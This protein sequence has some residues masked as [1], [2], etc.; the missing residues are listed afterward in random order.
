MR[1]GYLTCQI[2]NGASKINAWHQTGKIKYFLSH[3]LCAL[4]S[5]LLISFWDI[6]EIVELWRMTEYKFGCKVSSYILRVL[7][8]IC[9][10]CS[11]NI[12]GFR[13]SGPKSRKILQYL[14]NTSLNT[15]DFPFMRTKR[16]ELAGIHVHI[17]RISF[18]GD[19][20]WEIHCNTF[21]QKKII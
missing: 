1:L 16:I 12:C 3:F 20:G 6:F 14:T 10:W 19:L 8:K 18:T 17:L 2:P 4:D 11:D 15:K 21:D 5:W 9:F 13:V 7:P